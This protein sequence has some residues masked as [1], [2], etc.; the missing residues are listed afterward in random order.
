[1]KQERVACDFSPGAR[2][3]K[4]LLLPSFIRYSIPLAC[5][6][7]V[8]RVRAGTKFMYTNIIAEREEKGA[9]EICIDAGFHVRSRRT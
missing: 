9:T 8:R 2:N 5:K 4:F 6:E 1:M 3:L 7:S